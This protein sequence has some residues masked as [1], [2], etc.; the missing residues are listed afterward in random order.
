MK[1]TAALKNALMLVPVPIVGHVVQTDA[2]IEEGVRSRESLNCG[3]VANFVR[4]P[5]DVNVIDRRWP[6]RT[7]QGS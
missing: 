6:R 3:R 7:F 4:R 1:P 5:L 2:G